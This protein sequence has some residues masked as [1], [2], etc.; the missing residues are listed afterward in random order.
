MIKKK[1]EQI[2]A[3]RVQRLGRHG[4]YGT[5]SIKENAEQEKTRYIMNDWSPTAEPPQCTASS[6]D[7]VA[8]NILDDPDE[9]VHVQLIPPSLDL[10]LACCPKTGRK[11]NC[12]KVLLRA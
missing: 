4:L 10:A 12:R 5:S 1:R 7:T 2:A 3:R 6:E 11:C 9:K 8:S